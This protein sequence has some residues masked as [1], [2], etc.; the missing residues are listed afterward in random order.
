MAKSKT[1]QRAGKS[2]AAKSKAAPFGKIATTGISAGTRNPSKSLPGQLA[3][4]SAAQYPGS[5]GKI[6][7]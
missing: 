6:N 2:K 4:A 5:Y 7:N 1:R 3:N